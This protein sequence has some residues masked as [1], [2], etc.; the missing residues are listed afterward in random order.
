VYQPEYG[1]ESP[2]GEHDWRSRSSSSA[3]PRGRGGG[4]G[5]SA[6]GGGYGDGGGYGRGGGGGNGRGQERAFS[7][8]GLGSSERGRKSR[9]GRNNEDNSNGYNVGRRGG[10]SSRDDRSRSSRGDLTDGSQDSPKGGGFQKRDKLPQIEIFNPDE[11]RYARKRDWTM[12]HRGPLVRLTYYRAAI[13]RSTAESALRYLEA[14]DG[15]ERMEDESVAVKARAFNRWVQEDLGEK[16]EDEDKDKWGWGVIVLASESARPFWTDCLGTGYTDPNGLL[17][18]TGIGRPEEDAVVDDHRIIYKLG[19]PL[20][21][22]DGLE[23][24]DPGRL[25]ILMRLLQAISKGALNPDG[26]NATVVE[27]TD[28]WGL[29]PKPW[30]RLQV[31][32][33]I[34]WDRAAQTLPTIN[35]ILGELVLQRKTPDPVR[36]VDGA[37]AVGG[38]VPMET[39]P[40][41]SAEEGCK[42]LEW[43]YQAAISVYERLN[44]SLRD[45]ERIETVE[46]CLTLTESPVKKMM[47]A[48]CMATLATPKQREKV[49]ELLGFVET[50][51]V[52]A[53]KRIKKEKKPA[54]PTTPASTLT[55]KRLLSTNASSLNPIK[56]KGRTDGNNDPPNKTDQNG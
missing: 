52:E 21:V 32:A 34:N 17:K 25:T 19:M 12:K 4:G 13:A 29:K 18:T 7:D 3:G 38:G 46:A 48:S 14:A 23:S 42:E 15:G 24:N 20:F 35:G 10:N 47:M 40:N 9:R 49:G 27:K 56:T 28:G 50:A 8:R 39:E 11:W 22:W 43:K 53:R 45:K 16:Q 31:R 41:V 6:R 5:G 26:Y 36:G 30:C 44:K 55:V 51:R 37:V 33:S 1:W 2:T 54:K